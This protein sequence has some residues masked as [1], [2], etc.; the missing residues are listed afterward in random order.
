MYI[1]KN[2]SRMA[3]IQV[4]YA[5]SIVNNSD[6]NEYLEDNSDYK[7]MNKSFF[8]RLM[9]YFSKEVDFENIYN[10]ALTGIQTIT[11][12]EILNSI[13]KVSILEMLFEKTPLAIIIN[14]YVEISKQ[15]LSTSEVKLLNAIL[16]KISKNINK[17]C[18]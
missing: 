5:K 6:I 17:T 15:F 14:E 13:I 8:N 10:Q 16:D 12:Y 3:A 9:T 18:Q 1:S 7:K 11:N 4:M 2:I